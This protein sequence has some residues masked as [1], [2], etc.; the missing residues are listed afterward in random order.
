[1]LDVKFSSLQAG[2]DKLEYVLDTTEKRIASWEG[3]WQNDKSA[4]I[5]VGGMGFVIGSLGG[6]V[7]WTFMG[8]KVSE[9]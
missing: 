3:F 1:M 7:K 9:Y 8:K 2:F 5:L 4:W 6:I